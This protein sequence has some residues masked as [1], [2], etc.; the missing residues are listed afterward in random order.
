MLF[1]PLLVLNVLN[2]KLMRALKEL[3]RKRVDMV[4]NAR[5]KN[6]NNI[7]LVLI[8][9]VVVFVICQMPALVN[10]SMH[11]LLH[12]SSRRCRGIHFFVSIHSNI[13]VVTNSSINFVIYMAF[14][15]RFRQSILE[16]ACCLPFLFCFKRNQQARNNQSFGESSNFQTFNCCNKLNNSAIT[17]T[18]TA[19]CQKNFLVQNKKLP[20]TKKIFIEN[21]QMNLDEIKQ[22]PEKKNNSTNKIT[23]ENSADARNK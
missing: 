8:I 16:S 14:N 12:D 18:T 4:Q 13:F 1:L 22:I 9:V 7:T 5:Q 11:S 23:E 19:L 2:V 20:E 17:K 21:E 10:R 15:P 6:D 3:K